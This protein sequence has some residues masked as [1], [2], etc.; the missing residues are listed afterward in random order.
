MN[1]HNL[2]VDFGKHKDESMRTIKEI[3]RTLKDISSYLEVTKMQNRNI[4]NL[5]NAI[6]EHTDIKGVAYKMQIEDI[7][8][9]EEG[10]VLRSIKKLI[11]KL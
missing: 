9:A 10:K 5:L 1:T 8:L 2:I 6:S 4:I 3:L 11:K 7:D